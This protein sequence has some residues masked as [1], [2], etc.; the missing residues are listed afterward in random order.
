MNKYKGIDLF[1]GI[2]GFRIAMNH[3]NVECVFSSD[4][5]KFAQQ[6]YKANFN[7]IPTGD[8]KKVEAKDIPEF[9]ILTA[10][11]PCQPFSYAGEKQGFNDEIR[12]TLFFDV[13]RIIEYHKPPMVFLENVKGIKSHDGG[14]TLNII[15]D[16]LRKQGYFPH[17]KILSSL[18]YG[19]PQKR[20]RWY[21]V[22]FRKDIQFEWPEPI[23]GK[24]I[25]RDIVDLNDNNPAL[26][27]PKFE[28]DRIDHHFRNAKKGDRIQHDNSKYKPNTKKGKYGIYSFQK[29]D[30]SLRFH[31]GDSAKTQI[32]EAF[33][34]CLDTYASTIIANRTPKL[35]D[36]RRKLSV[37]ESKRLQGFPDDFIFPVS[38]A[39]AYK[40]LG[41]SV[42]VPI[43]EKIMENMIKTYENVIEG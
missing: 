36:I 1:C 6:T 15:L 31:V 27:L 23:E 9:D 11:F 32:Q 5:D 17:W 29:P 22:A 43:I 39:Q 38:D 33:Y 7:E 41:N 2:G 3:N 28:L 16:A 26:A 35:W 24:P 37:L 13:C 4:N 20:E 10:G 21:C 19:L 34:S 18:D 25:L 12:G 8:I 14:K 30:G 42:S 40:Q